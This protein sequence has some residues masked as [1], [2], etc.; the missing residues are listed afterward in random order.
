MATRKNIEKSEPKKAEI[1]L[2]VKVTAAEKALAAFLPQGASGVTLVDELAG[3][4]A[5][6]AC[7]LL[8]GR[9]SHAYS[10]ETVNRKT[11][12]VKTMY[13]VAVDLVTSTT[14]NGPQGLQEGEPGDKVGVTL[15]DKLM[16]LRYLRPGN[17]VACEFLGM[18]DFK[19]DESGEARRCGRYRVHSDTLPKRTPMNTVRRVDLN[20]EDDF[21]EAAE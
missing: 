13:G 1:A 8:V 21:E 6:E 2:P 16:Q 5:K 9:I 11:G 19:D 7:P 17:L 10:W 3:T 18:A 14:I 20:E 12:E 4:W 15:A